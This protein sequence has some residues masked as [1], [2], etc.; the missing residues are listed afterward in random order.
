MF[1][2]KCGTELKD[3]T[4]FCYCCGSKAAPEEELLQKTEPVE[5]VEAESVEIVEAEPVEVAEPLYQ[6]PVE[7]E[8]IFSDEYEEEKESLSTTALLCGLFGLICSDTCIFAILGI[9]LSRIG[10]AK[11]KRYGQMTGSITG[12]AKAGKIMGTIGFILGLIPVVA[13]LL[14]LAYLLCLSILINYAFLV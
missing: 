9:I 14:F 4:L 7:Q 5:T 2:H 12:K 13:I 6:Q 8:I 11:A 3:G 10:I 1:C